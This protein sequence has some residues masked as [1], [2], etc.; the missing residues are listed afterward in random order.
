MVITA[1]GIAVWFIAFQ[2]YRAEGIEVKGGLRVQTL[3]SMSVENGDT[4]YGF[5][6]RR[7]RLS[8]KG[9]FLTRNL[10]YKTQVAFE[11]KNAHLLDFIANY[12]ATKFISLQFG[13]WK[14][15][16]MRERISSSGKLEL[17][18]RGLLNSYFNLERDIGADLILSP[19]DNLRV[20]LASFTGWGINLKRVKVN[21]NLLYVARIEFAPIGKINYD[22]PNLNRK[23]LVNLGASFSFF[24]IDGEQE[25]KK[26]TDGRKLNKFMG[27][28]IVIEEDETKKVLS[29]DL[30]QGEF[31]LKLWWDIISFELE[32]VG[33]SFNRYRFSGLRVQPSFV[34]FDK[35]GVALRY[36]NVS[37]D[38]DTFPV[39]S[40]NSLHEITAGPSYYFREHNAKIQFDY[41]A[42][43]S[44]GE[45]ENHLVRLQFQLYVK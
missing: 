9:W 38:T 33:G 1:G 27:N 42:I 31:D 5:S 26:F 19:H 39:F 7:A 4:N 28:Y 21:K 32:A 3:G 18:D 16:F 11:G 34:L 12:K 29:G 44:N 17:V 13:Q 40:G 22:Q 37:I 10:K 43:I 20:H 30:M 35:L 23:K 24:P 8:F 25:A 41:S 15:P 36:S 14:V 2:L 45:I 6:I